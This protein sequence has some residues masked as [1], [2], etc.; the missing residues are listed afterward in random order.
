MA[1]KLNI[2]EVEYNGQ[3]YEVEAAEGTPEEEIFKSIEGYQPPAPAA[4][5]TAAPAA[6]PTTQA[7]QAPAAP[8]VPNAWESQ[9][10]QV[11]ANDRTLEE[12]PGATQWLTEQL[13][14]QRSF[15][16]VQAEFNANP[17]F[18][19][20]VLPKDMADIW[21]KNVAYVQTPE[22]RYQLEIGNQ[23]GPSNRL[24]GLDNP[25]EPTT[26]LGELGQSAV[27]STYQM[28]NTLRGAAAVGADLVG[29]DDTALKL[30]NDY[31][32][33][34]AAIE[35]NLPS[36]AGRFTEIE[37]VG[38]AGRWLMSTLGEQIPQLAASMGAG[39]AVG[40]VTKKF[41]KEA[42]EKYV[43][44]QVAEGVAEDVARREAAKMV[45]KS[46]ITGNIAGAGAVSEVQ[47]VGSI[48]GDT[49]G[50]TGELKPW[51]SLLAGTAAAAL[52]TIVPVHLLKKFGGDVANDAITDGLVK[53]LGKEGASNFLM[54]GGTEVIQTII[55]Q[56]PTGEPIDWDAVVEAG[57]RGGVGGAA[58]GTAVETY[59]SIRNRNTRNTN[60]PKGPVDVAPD[61]PSITPIEAP[62]RKNTKAY[63]QQIDQVQDQ[64]VERITSLTENWENAP[65]FEVHQNFNKVAGVSNGAIGVISNG[66]VLINTENVLKAAKQRG[67]SPDIIV[68]SVTFHEGL[69]HHGLDLQ[70]GEALDDQLSTMLASSPV[71]QARV[72]E[73]LNGKGKDAY[74]EDPNRDIRAF[75]ELL[76]EKS[77]NGQLPATFINRV[78]NTIKDFGRRMGLDL[79][80]S[81]REVEAILAMSHAAV[82]SGKGRNA[83]S[84]GFKFMMLG[85]K[86]KTADLARLEFAKALERSGVDVSEGGRT[87]TRIGWFKAPDNKWRFEVPDQAGM[88]VKIGDEG[89]IEELVRGT[90]VL[91][92]DLEDFKNETV[93]SL[94]SDKTAMEELYFSSYTLDGVLARPDLFEAY[95]EL[96]EIDVT[97]LAYEEAVKDK[98]KLPLGFY[99]PESKIIYLN[100]SLNDTLAH[101]VL[102]HEVQHVVQDIEGFAAGG[103]PQYVIDEMPDDLLMKGAKQFIKWLKAQ[104]VPTEQ[105]QMERD[106]AVEQIQE[107]IKGQ[108]YR[109]LRSFFNAN[110]EFMDGARKEA[111]EH[112]FGEVEARDTQARMGMTQEELDATVPY[113]LD[114]E[115]RNIDPESFIFN[116]DGGMPSDMVAANDNRLKA[117]T[118]PDPDASDTEIISYYE[119]SA[120]YH[121]Q[122]AAEARE[123]GKDSKAEDL[124]HRA[125]LDWK[126]ARDRAGLITPA[127]RAAYHR[128]AAR[129]FQ[130]K[131]DQRAARGD[132]QGVERYKMFRDDALYRAG[133]IAESLLST[134]HNKYM[135][136]TD[137]D[138]VEMTPEEI[139]ALTPEEIFEAENA[140]ALLTKM[141]EGYT[142]V[143]LNYEELEDE[144]RLRNLQPSVV[145][146]LK[147]VQPGEITK[148][149]FMHDI[150]MGKLDEKLSA[151]YAKM[152]NGTAT[153]MDHATFAE[154]SFKR[155]EFAARIWDE[156]SEIA[157]ALN[158][159]KQMH[160]TRRR[161]R[162]ALETAAQFKKGSPYEILNDPDDFYKYAASVMDQINANKEKLAK[163]SKTFATNALNLP[164]AL[165]S[166]MDLSA[167]LRQGL[168]L[169]HKPAWWRSFGSMFRY[170][171]DEQAFQDLQEEI[172]SRPTYSAMMRGKLAL[173]SVDGNLSQREEDFQTEWANKVPGVRMSERAYVGF[174][175]KL[176]ADVFDQMYA[177]LPE[178]HT[179]Q[180]LKDIARFI[181]AASGRGNLHKSLQSSA[182][183]LNG[184]LFSPRLMS[185]R[186]TLL[187]DLFRPKTYMSMNPVA[188]KEYFKSLLAV[189]TL[190]IMV[191]GLAE[192]GGAEVE[193]DPRSTDFGRIKVGNTR[194]D[195]LGGSAQYVTLA[196]RIATNSTKTADGFIKEYG[197]G[198]NATTAG[199][200]A[201]RFL[202]YKFAPIPSFI[203]D[204]IDRKDAV[205]RPFE[206]DRAIIQ[207]MLP[208]IV[209]NIYENA[210]EMGYAKATV[211][212]IPEFFGIGANNYKSYTQDPTRELDPPTHFDMKTAVDGEYGNVSVRNGTVFLDDKAQLEWG[213]RLN[214]YY[215]EWMK[216]EMSK[217]EW[218]KYTTEERKEVIS[219]V[220]N[221]ARD[222][223]KED[224][225]ELLAIE[226]E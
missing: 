193:K 74:L 119:K 47:E 186:L 206:V 15:E 13:A 65:Q 99:D 106:I 4:P 140:A 48:Y 11:M 129:Y 154:Y 17:A 138:K 35:Q 202:R 21:A 161:V 5:S 9:S 132:A 105:Q 100:T 178:G 98:S 53:R 19:G 78:K 185:S 133:Q 179:D 80:Y 103:S 116:M 123:Q 196:A 208:M 7:P 36:S 31:L 149:L 117:P 70:F 176:R 56:L 58:A 66:K 162:G 33:Q 73:W 114:I 204:A 216:D 124:L 218:N 101:W 141:Q 168:F 217:P 207:R 215:T 148:R 146:G 147:S 10:N 195:I 221:D 130:T 49:Y 14:K 134:S 171:T 61:A 96:A 110:H 128:E 86:A 180:D 85:P 223:A 38:D 197:V 122:K 226:E 170:W 144:V 8:H 97:R 54:E 87:R 107:K 109:G 198:Y 42:V 43:E 126:M 20:V 165:M 111:Y 69:G 142:P 183:V 115:D 44:K 214:R 34:G 121:S 175:N 22:G 29:A 188:R 63:K 75:E 192:M 135:M 94:L 190:A 45:V 88:I 205:G 71:Y 27:R 212:A 131:V 67:V 93:L 95:P 79:E 72:K 28:A 191:L 16:E 82:V 187:T 219:E 137:P 91:P 139:E 158:A 199:D 153:A 6:A 127:E 120:K 155:R 50:A 182:P 51:A 224:M 184:L 210:E 143:H 152:Q 89:I 81:T 32:E 25:Q 160:Y 150:V 112:L 211:M 125:N 200:A 201:V 76:A 222:A 84:N 2:Y 151:L 39:Y 62:A 77:E 26:F 172:R 167:P 203:Y 225:L 83:A 59:N 57:L 118:S 104:D 145:M 220:R 1:D 40:A 213:Q 64:V 92:E 41:A 30:V 102:L 166:T 108:D 157:R 174:L 181:N 163:D 3:I 23:V 189:G 113:S 24:S 12:V 173:S 169:I 156:H 177:Q 52:D 60:L 18:A 46:G 37:S 194:F 136:M 90:T 209:T 55:E 68:N 159:F 164:R